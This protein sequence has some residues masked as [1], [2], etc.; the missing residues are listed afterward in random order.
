M[1][2]RTILPVIALLLASSYGLFVQ[3]ATAQNSI[4]AIG[5]VDDNTGN[6]INSAHTLGAGGSVASSRNGVGDYTITLTSPGAFVG[7]VPMDF[8]VEVTAK[9]ATSN[10]DVARATIDSVNANEV[11][12]LV[13]TSDLE[14][15]SNVNTAEARDLP[16]FF[17][18]YRTPTAFPDPGATKF[19]FATG[20]VDANGDLLSGVGV[21]GIAVQSSRNGEGDYFITLSKTGSFAGDSEDDYVVILTV[22]D[23]TDQDQAIRGDTVSVVSDDEVVVNVHTDDVQTNAGDDTVAP[24]DTEFFFT[25]YKIPA[26]TGAGL[27][28]SRLLVAMASVAGG[29][30]NLFTPGFSFDGGT[31]ASSRTAEGDYQ[32]VITSLNAFAGRVADDFVLQLHLN[33]G[34]HDDIF[35]NGR[36]LVTDDSTL[37]I[38]VQTQD[39]EVDGQALGVPEDAN[40]FLL[41][42][43]AGVSVQPDLR[44][45]RKKNLTLQF[46]DGVYNAGAAGQKISVGVPATGKKKYWFTL[47][48]DGR[49][50][51]DVFLKAKRSGKKIKAKYFRLTGGRENVTASMTTASYI[52][53]SVPPGKLI[54]YEA[55]AKYTNPL[56]RP[57]KT[58]RFLARGQFD[59]ARRDANKATLS[60]K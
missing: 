2:P 5:H 37:T 28:D 41:V 40:F 25:I 22:E 6:L 44:I 43:D 24:E 50:S 39:L 56:I 35:I 26:G 29:S 7:N 12:I 4:L 45:G 10:D 13:H 42:L 30:G 60:P 58:L 53:D 49:V 34:N 23:N 20:K 18:V 46:G 57:S 19:L 21:N 38:D 32:V 9:W 27:A 59:Q 15:P 55:Q 16:F 31:V 17:T 3:A 36:L 54:R 11:T 47:E 1:N 48:N 14:D 52:V 51:D 33:Q 8:L